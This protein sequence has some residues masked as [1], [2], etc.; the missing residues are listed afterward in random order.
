MPLHRWTTARAGW[1]QTKARHVHVLS[2]SRRPRSPQPTK[3]PIGPAHRLPCRG[4]GSRALFAGR[5]RPQSSAPRH[6]AGGQGGWCGHWRG[7]GRFVRRQVG[8]FLCLGPRS[9]THAGTRRRLDRGR[10]SGRFRQRPRCLGRQTGA[11]PRRGTRLAARTHPQSR[12]QK[13]APAGV[14]SLPGPGLAWVQ[15]RTRPAGRIR[16]RRVGLTV[17]GHTGAVIARRKGQANTAWQRG[18]HTRLVSPL[19]E[20]TKHNM[21]RLITI[22]DGV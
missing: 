21:G 3:R 6:G 4:S 2:L 15:A 9:P 13:G 22:P 16:V 14:P 19:F 7:A 10:R 20:Q 11:I 12:G 5:Q 8:F 18:R 17:T 1:R